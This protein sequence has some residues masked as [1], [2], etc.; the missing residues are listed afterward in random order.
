MQSKNI[1]WESCLYVN[2]VCAENFTALLEIVNNVYHVVK[3]VSS[4]NNMKKYSTVYGVCNCKK[5]QNLYKTEPD[6]NGK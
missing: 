5:V 4:T 6:Y 1:D 3:T 2:N